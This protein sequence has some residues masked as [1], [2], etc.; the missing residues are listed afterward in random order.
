[1]MEGSSA[2]EDFRRRHEFFAGI[3]SD[4]CVFDTME[5]KQKECFIPNIIYFYDLQPVS[6]YARE[7]AEFVNLYSRWRGTNRFQALARTLDLLESRPEV[8]RRGL[9]L[10]S[11]AALKRFIASGKPLGNPTLRE[12]IERTRDA[13][14]ERLL[15]WSE[16]VNRDVARLVRGLA[17]FPFVRD[18]L[19]KLRPRA[20]LMVVSATPIA[21][22][23]AEWQEHDLARLVSLIAGQEAGSKKEALQAAAARGYAKDRMLMVG[24]APSDCEAARA[25]GALF[26][27]IV[28]GEEEASWERFLLEGID[29]FLAGRFAGAYEE[30]LLKHFLDKLPSIPPWER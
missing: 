28:P 8:A 19:E 6:K 21:A 3:D 23:R 15:E 14:L 17:P 29:R 7:A 10:R 24:D 25:A 13:E 27:P 1:M 20:D 26:F 4:G 18:S 12:E 11:T 5:L 2:L 16:T 30:D 22:L 9:K